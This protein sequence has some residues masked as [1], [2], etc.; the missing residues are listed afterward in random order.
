MIENEKSMSTL[1][2]TV[3]FILFYSFIILIVGSFLYNSFLL[4]SPKDYRIELRIKDNKIIKPDI[5]ITIDKWN[6]IPGYLQRTIIMRTNLPAL[7]SFIAGLFVIF[8]LRKLYKEI[9]STKNF[10]IINAKYLNR[11]GLAALLYTVINFTINL[12]LNLIISFNSYTPASD[13]I[14][15][16][17]RLFPKFNFQLLIF[18]LIIVVISDVYLKVTEIQDDLKLTI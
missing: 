16:S 12:I 18:G 13:N 14:H 10:S 17:S 1:I 4:I 11:I 15:V 6:K 9:L 5:N 3:L 2:K 7:L 8:F